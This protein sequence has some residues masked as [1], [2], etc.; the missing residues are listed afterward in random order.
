MAL[1]NGLTN[2]TFLILTLFSIVPRSASIPCR[3][4]PGY[5]FGTYPTGNNGQRITRTCAWLTQGSS[6]TQDQR[7]ANWCRRQWL[8]NVIENKCPEA[9]DKC[10]PGIR[11]NCVNLSPRDTSPGY[12]IDWNDRYG[13]QFNCAYYASG[14]NCFIFGN[15]FANYGWTAKQA[16]CA[17]G[18]GRSSSGGGRKLE[19]APGS[20][21]Q[22]SKLRGSK[23]EQE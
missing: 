4:D 3:D 2:A 23:I 14:D 19:D 12:P 9:C 7:K 8:Y 18:G 20:T 6:Q 16:C 11:P 15:G 5:T 21:A 1:T 13:P 10:N 22:Q 17:C